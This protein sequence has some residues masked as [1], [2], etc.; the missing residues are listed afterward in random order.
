[1]YY[2]LTFG[3]DK[4]TWTDWGLIPESPPMVAPPAPKTNL[5]DIPGRV[6]GALDLSM[7]PFGR[8]IYQRVSGTWSFLR[9]IDNRMTR[10]DIGNAVRKYLHGRQTTVRME[11]DPG[12]YYKGRFTVGAPSSGQGPMRITIGYDLEPVRYNM[13]GTVD[14]TWVNDW[15]S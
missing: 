13:D 15:S 9:E 5:V 7:Q 8:L 6:R 3:E 1:M 11:E 14:T 12:H 2:S 4:N 10:L